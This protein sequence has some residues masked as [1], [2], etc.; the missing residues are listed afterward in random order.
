[1]IFICNPAFAE[2]KNQDKEKMDVQC[3]VEIIIL[4]TCTVILY[5][6]LRSI[7]LHTLL[8]PYFYVLWKY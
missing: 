3:H 5:L 7:L 8:E 1:M 4:N 6:L 2:N